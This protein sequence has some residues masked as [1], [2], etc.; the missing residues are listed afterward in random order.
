MA[1]TRVLLIRSGCEH[2]LQ[3]LLCKHM[4]NSRV[5]RIDTTTYS[6]GSLVPLKG[7]F[8]RVAKEHE[9]TGRVDLPPPPSAGRG[10]ASVRGIMPSLACHHERPVSGDR[11]ATRPAC[12]T[13]ATDTRS[14]GRC[15]GNPAASPSCSCTAGRAPAR[16]RPSPPVRSRALPHRALRP[17]RLR[18]QHPHA[19]T[20]EPISRRTPP[21]TSSPTWN[22]CASHL[23]IDRWQVFGGS[24]GS[25]LALAYAETHP[26]RVTELVLR[27]IFTLRRRSSL[28]FYQ[29]GA[30]PVFPDA[31]GG[32]RRARY[33]RPSAA[34]SSR[35]TTGAAH[36]PG[37]G[38]ARTGRRSPGA[39]EADA[40][41]SCPDAA[42]DRPV[43][44]ARLRR[45]VRAHRE[46]LLRQRRL[47]RGG[48][49]DRRCRR[50][51]GIPGVIVQGRYD[52]CTPVM[53]AWDLHRPGPRPSSRSSPTPVTPSTSPASSTPS[54]TA[55]DRFA[56]DSREDQPPDN[57]DGAE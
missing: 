51:C 41:R 4:S 25:R 7:D 52:M 16:A 42:T 17:A 26:E 56:Q 43:R 44:R 9:A 3:R 32:L 36:R 29:E 18:A 35:P 2:L 13:S 6:P 38:G 33:P 24:W 8:T 22:G 53:T 30:S 14:T 49:A 15:R 55:T 45:R 21:G 54:S 23:G 5:R 46:P 20:P 40:S 37:P 50:G 27:G 48:P 34:T 1:R 39:W 47:V 10:A 57:A 28:W 11:T 31:V 12:S 19:S